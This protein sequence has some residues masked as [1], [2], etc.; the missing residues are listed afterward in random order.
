MNVCHDFQR[1]VLS[2]SESRTQSLLMSLRSLEFLGVVPDRNLLWSH[3]FLSFEN[4]EHK[5]FSLMTVSNKDKITVTILKF[6]ERMPKMWRKE[7]WAWK[8]FSL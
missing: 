1:W 6:K 2:R 5:T 3:F 4:L 8:G 7:L